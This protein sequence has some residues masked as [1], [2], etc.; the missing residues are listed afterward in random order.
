MT[1]K[2][3]TCHIGMREMKSVVYLAHPN[4]GQYGFNYAAHV[5]P[6]W[7]VDLQEQTAI[8]VTAWI[9]ILGLCAHT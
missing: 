6:D 1:I 9:V 5:P 3:Q 7:A 8:A 2:V 4:V